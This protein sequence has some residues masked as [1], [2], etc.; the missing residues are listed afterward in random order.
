MSDRLSPAPTSNI[1]L[2]VKLL[3]FGLVV[4]YLAQILAATHFQSQTNDEGYHL[5]AG[6]RYWQCGDFGINPEHPP[7]LK[8]VASAPL[9]LLHTPAPQGVCGQ[10]S[11]DKYEGYGRSFHWYYQEGHD[12]DRM[13]IIARTAAAVF[14][15]VLAVG[16]FLFATEL[17]GWLAG[18]LALLLLVSEPTLIAHGALVTTDTAVTALMF[19]TVF[20]SYRYFQKRTLARLLLTGVLTGL[21]FAAKHSGVLVIPVLALLT[22]FEAWRSAKSETSAKVR[23][24][25]QHIAALAAIGA[26]SLTVLWAFYGFRYAP[27]PN[28]VGMAVPLATFLQMSQEQGNRS[29]MVVHMI[30]T[31]ARYHLLPEAYLY[32]FVDVLT[33]SSPGQPPFLLGKLYPHGQWFYFPVTFVIKSTLGFLGLFGLALV[34]VPW[35]KSGLGRQVFYL[36]APVAVVMAAGMTSGLNIGYRHVLPMVPY[37]C[38]LLGATASLLME[39]SRGWRVAVIVLLAL[40]VISSL[41]TFPNYIP[42]SNEAWGGPSRTYRYLTDANADW[43]QGMRAVKRYL[44]DNNISDCW[45]AYDGVTSTEYYGVNCTALPPN[46]WAGGGPV[47]EQISGNLLVSAMTISGIEWENNELNPYREFLHREPD[48]V[49]AGT[50]LVYKGTFDIREISAVQDIAIA[51]RMNGDGKY[52][53]ALEPG[54]RAVALTPQSVR[55]RLQLGEALAGLKRTDEA[56]KELEAALQLAAAQPQW[57]PNEIAEGQRALRGLAQSH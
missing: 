38:V 21:T 14:S 51:K 49:I 9:W 45:F 16:C 32:G 57:Y 11:S 42:Y 55:A 48:A 15:C 29:V 53:E 17:F 1:S 54:Q 43:G 31:L 52:A 40:H 10:E 24:W 35:R 46:Q 7:L 18:L 39:R 20:A 12:P 3:A 30:P 4:L 34:A 47:P 56:R 50:V 28:G 5:M 2:R 13:M 19:A 6:Y 37:L 23:I 22:L 25:L 41:R 27:R 33:I 36:A 26:V 44:D 8:F